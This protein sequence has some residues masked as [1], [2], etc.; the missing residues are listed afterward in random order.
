MSMI[1]RSITSAIKSPWAFKNKFLPESLREIDAD[2]KQKL[3]DH[4]LPGCIKTYWNICEA[5]ALNDKNYMRIALEN[6]LYKKFIYELDILAQDEHQFVVNH[7]DTPNIEIF[8]VSINIGVDIDRRLNFKRSVYDIVS[9]LEQLKGN[10]DLKSLQKE[11]KENEI[12]FEEGMLD[13]NLE[14]VWLYIHPN[15]RACVLLSFDAFFTG[16]NPLS[17]I[18]EGKDVMYDEREMETH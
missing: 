12:K 1:H 16:L 18:F 14:N 9:S 17:L 3:K 15:A 8:N 2:T 4:A 7:R 11:A 13:S 5:I 6:S 10:I